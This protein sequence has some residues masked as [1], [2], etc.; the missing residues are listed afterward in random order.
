MRIPTRI[1]FA[2]TV[3]LAASSESRADLGVLVADGV[4][5]P[6]RISVLA[7]PAP[8]RAG[9]SQWNVLVQDAAGASVEEARIELSFRRVGDAGS[10]I[11]SEARPGTHPFYRSS[12]VLLPAATNWQVAVNVHGPKGSASLGFEIRVSPRAGPWREFWPA[13]LAPLLAVGLFALHQS[14]ALRHRRAEA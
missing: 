12:E 11:Q 3:L 7:S 6:Y 14:L 9:R 4:R 5:G 13:L 2:L 1:A 10:L 8:L